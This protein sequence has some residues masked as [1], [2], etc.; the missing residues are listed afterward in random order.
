MAPRQ[1]SRIYQQIEAT[2][3]YHDPSLYARLGA[4]D[5]SAVDDPDANDF[6]PLT[7]TKKLPS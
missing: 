5:V 1:S 6:I 3:D 2:A 7:A 4:F